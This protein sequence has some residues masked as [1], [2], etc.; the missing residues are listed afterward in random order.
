MASGHVNR[1]KNM[2]APTNAANMK[3]ALANPVPSTHGTF[4]PQRGV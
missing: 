1:I 3:K 2:A 4:G